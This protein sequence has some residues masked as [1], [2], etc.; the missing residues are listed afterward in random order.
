M[1]EPLAPTDD[2][3]Y[4]VA[5]H[6]VPGLGPERFK[7][8]EQYFGGMRD[9]WRASPTALRSAGIAPL[10]LKEIISMRDKTAPDALMQGLA[11]KSIKPIH[12]R[13]PEYPELLA[14][15]PAPPPVL[16]ARGDLLPEDCNGIAVIGTRKASQYGIEMSKRL[17]SGLASL[18]I[19]VVSG[20]ARG[21]DSV[22]HR[23]ALDAGGR[24]VAVLAGGLDQIYPPENAEMACEIVARGCLL[25]EHKLGTRS[26]REH[27]PQRNRV[28]SGLC[29]GVVVVEAPMKSGTMHT[30]RW[31]LEQNR[32]VF[33][34]PGNATSYN[35]TGTNWLIKQGAK[36]T[37]SVDDIIEELDTFYRDQISTIERAPADV[38]SQIRAANSAS[39]PRRSVDNRADKMGKARATIV[40]HSKD[41]EAVAKVLASASVPIHI[42]EIVRESG[43][44]AS[45]VSAALSMMEIRGVVHSAHGARYS[46]A[47]M[48][49][50]AD[51]PMLMERHSTANN[52]SE[53]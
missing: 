3:Q 39:Q 37:T 26:R 14:E 16:Y 45:N 11:E 25:S 51:A 41:E 17:S 20:L 1:D 42:D 38:A 44:S 21:I 46:L 13:S 9:A 19:T 23:A 12:L 36:I 6:H 40:T 22:A 43:I 30:V 27:F 34:V 28:I 4:W 53:I 10:T 32:E 35:S 33:A 48:P 50:R 47:S 31:A 29:R 2:L 15:A 24:T 8:L 52:L 18:G 7:L 49:H 5:L